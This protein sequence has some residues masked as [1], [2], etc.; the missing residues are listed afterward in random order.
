MRTEMTIEELCEKLKEVSEA[1]G[2]TGADNF[3]DLYFNESDAPLNR[4]DVVMGFIYA[5]F[6][7]GIITFKERDS[8]VNC[9]FENKF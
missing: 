8:F 7:S 2:W 4:S 6:Y 9:M 3:F 5:M 1:K